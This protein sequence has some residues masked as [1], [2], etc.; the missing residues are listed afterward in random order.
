MPTAGRLWDKE[1]ADHSKATLISVEK[2]DPES[3][4]LQRTSAEDI[5]TLGW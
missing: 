2:Q 4:E 5:E 1:K 3:Q